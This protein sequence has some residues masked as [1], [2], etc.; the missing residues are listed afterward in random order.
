MIRHGQKHPLE[1]NRYLHIGVLH[2]NQTNGETLQLTTGKVVNV[3]S[4]NLLQFCKTVSDDSS[5]SN[6]DSLTQNLHDFIHVAQLITRLEEILH[7]LD[8]TLDGS[9]DLIDVLRLDNSLQVVFQDLGEV[10]C[11][12]QHL[13][14]ISSFAKQRLLCSSEPR[15]Y[16]RIS[17]QSGGLS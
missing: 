15:K 5:I 14:L 9:R 6:L 1:A 17:S 8:G 7:L 13:S 4:C 12:G 11:F 2:T 16:F 3:T 10:V